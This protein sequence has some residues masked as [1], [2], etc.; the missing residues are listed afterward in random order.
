[1]LRGADVLFLCDY[2]LEP[3]FVPG[4]L[5][6]YLRVGRPIFA[7]S[8][9]TEL[10]DLI[11]QTQTG[12]ALHPEDAE[13]QERV[14]KDILTRGPIA[15]LNFAPQNTQALSADSVAEQL[16]SAINARG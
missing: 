6:D 14:W 15:A 5:F 1:M 12:V 7:L 2:D 13:G 3:Y 10:R 8:A 9:N 16:A 11:H 4:K